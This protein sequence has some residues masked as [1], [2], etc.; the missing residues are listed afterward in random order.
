MLTEPNEISIRLS[1]PLQ[2][3]VLCQ[4]YNCL[5]RADLKINMKYEVMLIHLSHEEKLDF[6]LF[7]HKLKLGN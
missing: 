5:V 4:F 1:S 3:V 7:L 2:N 6:C